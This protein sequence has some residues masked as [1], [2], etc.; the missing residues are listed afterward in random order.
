MNI[1]RE[2]VTEYE[3]HKFVTEASQIGLPPGRFPRQIDTE[4]GNRMAFILRSAND[5]AAQYAQANGCIS[6]TI[7]ND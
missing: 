7:L 5:E 3:T 1:T 4:L 6:L 2:M